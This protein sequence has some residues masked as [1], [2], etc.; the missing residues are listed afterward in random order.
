[1]NSYIEVAVRRKNNAKD[2]LF[3]FL[4]TMVPLVIGTFI[5][6]LFLKSGDMFRLAIA[7]IICALLYYFAYKV[8][9]NF[10]VEWEYTLVENEIRFSKI[11][12]KNKRKEL[13]TINLSKAEIIA[14]T[15]DTENNHR[16]KNSD[17]TKLNFS[18][19]TN[20]T[21]YFIITSNDKGNKVC[22][23]FEP[24]SRMLENFATTLRG[25]FFQ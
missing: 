6:N 16:F 4:L 22:I 24:D 17:I 9:C 15:D 21:T 23:E 10:Y 11:I 1:M 3:C 7:T 20:N 2:I 18:S 5:F 8:F 14:R 12:N 19:Q 25:K 13:M